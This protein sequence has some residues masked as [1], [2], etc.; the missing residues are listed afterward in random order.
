MGVTFTCDRAD[1]GKHFKDG[2]RIIGHR[3]EDVGA[4]EIKGEYTLVLKGNRRGRGKWGNILP[5]TAVIE[6]CDSL[7]IDPHFPMREPTSALDN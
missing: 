7:Q 4:W 3:D 2:N 6:I 1:W 5:F